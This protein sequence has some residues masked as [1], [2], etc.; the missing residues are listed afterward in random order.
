MKRV[1]I[2][3]A[4]SYIG[5]SFEEWVMEKHPGEFE[6]DTVDMKDAA[7]KEKDFSRYE[8][9]FHVAG[10]AHA[11]I[12]HVSDG[13]KAL[14]YKVNC[15]L[16]IETALKAKKAGIKQ[17][18][19]MSSIIVYGDSA[20]LGKKK[21][22][23]K[24]TKPHPANFYGNSKWKADKELRKLSDRDFHVAVLRPPMI[25]GKESKG[26]YPMLSKL[27]KI[28]PIFPEVKNERSMLYIDNLCE[29]L[30]LLMKNGAEGIY[31][32]Q[33]EEYV[34]THRMVKEIAKC[35][36]H[37]IWI[38]KILNPFVWIVGKIPGKMSGMINKAFGNL[39]YEKS[40]SECFEGSY[41]VSNFEQ[42]ILATERK[43]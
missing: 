4:N 43:K 29:F 30:F 28:L 25:Y 11:D 38:T 3:G 12:G 35:A 18:V 23:Q 15:D 41:R 7:W 39:V 34:V 13:E 31:F 19:F 42:S 27:V 9:I 32:P 8:I 37:K 24:D 10:I 21:V 2:T 6:I 16:A 5:M 20:P 33:N 1:L 26:N 40:M 22:I 14:Y 36:G 17:F